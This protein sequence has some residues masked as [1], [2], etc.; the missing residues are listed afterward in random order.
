MTDPRIL[1][2]VEAVTTDLLPPVPRP[3]L[4]DDGYDWMVL[5]RGSG[6]FPVPATPDGRPLGSWPYQIV[7]HHN[8][9]ER[10]LYGI[11]AY[12]EGDIHVTGYWDKDARDQD[13][14]TYV[15]DDD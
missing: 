9:P 4:E 11:A 6:W 7:A 15:E 8:D 3:E 13:S 12:T 2:A 14:N 5:L 1:A 10:G